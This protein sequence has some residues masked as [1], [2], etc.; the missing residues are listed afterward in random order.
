MRIDGGKFLL[1][2]YPEN[3]FSE[4]FK[5]LQKALVSEGRLHLMAEAL[6]TALILMLRPL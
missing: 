3:M 2:G 6:V 5:W 1:E 4:G